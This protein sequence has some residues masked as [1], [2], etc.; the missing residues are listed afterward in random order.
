M[1]AREFCSLK[2]TIW[3]VN[4]S[5]AIHHELIYCSGTARR[6]RE[7][8]SSI[9]ET[10]SLYTGKWTNVNYQLHLYMNIPGGLFSHQMVCVPDSISH[11]WARQSSTHHWLWSTSWNEQPTM[12]AMQHCNLIKH[13]WVNLLQEL[14]TSWESFLPETR[15]SHCQTSLGTSQNLQSAGVLSLNMISGTYNQKISHLASLLVIHQDVPGSK[16][17]VYKALLGQVLH[18]WG[19]LTTVPQ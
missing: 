19:N 17:S 8:I 14:S 7:S 13:D 9:N 11:T 12:V 2:C 10:N 5:P 15:N 1:P 18:T 4:F 16:V 3:I 6:R